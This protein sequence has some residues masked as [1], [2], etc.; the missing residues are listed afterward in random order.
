MK[1]FFVPILL[2]LACSLYAQNDTLS[3]WSFSGYGEMYYS[4]DFGKPQNHLKDNFIY[5][6]KRH[7][8]INANLITV[9]ASFSDTKTRANVGLMV[10]NYAQYN[11]SAEP[12]WAQF[13]YEANIGVKLSKKHNLWLDA[14]IIPSHIGFES[15]KSADC[16]TLTRSILADNSPYYE[17][18]LKMGYTNKKEDLNIAFFVLNGWQRIQKPDFIQKPSIG[19]QVNYKATESWTLNYSN[20]IGTDKPDSLHSLRTFHNLYAQFQPKKKI[21]LILGFDIGSDKYNSTEYGFWF[22]PI[23]IVRYSITDKTRI[24]LRGEYYDDKNGIVIPT[25]SVTGFQVSGLSTNL[26][27][28]INDKVQWRIEGKIYSAT[29][30]VFLN[31]TND[32]FSMTTNLTIRL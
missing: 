19:M 3:K 14:G 18:G 5:N 11:L 9:Q 10:G 31:G 6:H 16:W 13:V 12:T 23:A 24:A 2:L 4:Y 29:D 7:N 8:E 20:F 27:Y 21:G 28:Q 22:S 17:T 15:A 26:D 1:F 25:I 32:N 30:N